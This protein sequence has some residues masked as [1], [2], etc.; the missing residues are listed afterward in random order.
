MVLI[1]C[2]DIKYFIFHDVDLNPKDKL[3]HLYK[4]DIEKNNI[5]GIIN[6]PCITLGGIIKINKEDFLEINGFPNDFWGWG[7]EDRA[8]YNRAIFYNKKINYN[9]YTNDKNINNIILK[10]NDIDDRKKTNYN[11]KR[12]N[13]YYKFKKFSKEQQKKHIYMSGLNNLKYSIIDKTTIDK[14][15]IKIK[16]SI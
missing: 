2:K 3:I 1:L 14:D 11:Y 6:S 12:D 16:V 15:I 4:K 9:H 13:E 5:L 7:V 8:L 10:F